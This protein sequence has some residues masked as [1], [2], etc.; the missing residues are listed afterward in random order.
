[1]GN[2]YGTHTTGSGLTGSH[3]THGTTGS[4][5]TGSNYGSTNA[6]PHDSNMA[7]KM[8]PRVGKLF[9]K[10]SLQS[11]VLT[12]LQTPTVMDAAAWATPTAPTE[13]PA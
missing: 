10:T 5:L 13:T 3:G 7:N 6:G 9:L 4:G 8:D 1:M 12:Y 11:S 2:T